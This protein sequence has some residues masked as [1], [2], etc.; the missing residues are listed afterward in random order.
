MNIEQL[1]LELEKRI[2]I[3]DKRIEIRSCN[4]FQDAED[5]IKHFH[6][7]AY[8]YQQVLKLIK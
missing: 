2:K 3:L 6:S 7:Q 4:N 1:R 5:I 8:A